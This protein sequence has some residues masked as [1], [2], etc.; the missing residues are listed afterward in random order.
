MIEVDDD[1]ITL[2]LEVCLEVIDRHERINQ[3]SDFDIADN[4]TDMAAEVILKLNCQ[5]N[6]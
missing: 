6:H 3:S 4:L 2:I 1:L 5:S